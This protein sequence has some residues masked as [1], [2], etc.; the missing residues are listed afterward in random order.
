MFK[1]ESTKQHR[2][3]ADELVLPA[4][5]GSLRQVV[6]GLRQFIDALYGDANHTTTIQEPRGD[7]LRMIFA[8][9]LLYFMVLY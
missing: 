9:G 8:T 5:P 3:A 2:N 1:N 6:A 7:H 4:R